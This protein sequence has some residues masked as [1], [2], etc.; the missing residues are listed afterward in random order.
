MTGTQAVLKYLK[1]HKRGLS[2]REAQIKLSVGRL[3]SVINR[4]RNRGYE[5]ETYMETGENEY[6]KYQYGRYYLVSEP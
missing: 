1:T 4:L 6:G 5:I 3:S 2:S